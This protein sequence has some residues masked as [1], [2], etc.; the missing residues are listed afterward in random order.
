MHAPCGA[1]LIPSCILRFPHRRCIATQAAIS[2]ICLSYLEKKRQ[3]SARLCSLSMERYRTAGGMIN[4]LAL[5]VVPLGNGAFKQPPGAPAFY[6]ASIY[7]HLTVSFGLPVVLLWRSEWRQRLAF[8]GRRALTAEE[9]GLRERQGQWGLVPMLLL[10]LGAAPVLSVQ[11]CS[12]GMRLG[13]IPT[14]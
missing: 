5:C 13:L 1:A 8:A 6:L 9:A 14:E 11:L 10:A 2:A 4:L 12:T 7:L 3:L